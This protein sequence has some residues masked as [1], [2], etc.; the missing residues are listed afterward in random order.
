MCDGH[1]LAGVDADR[2][3]DVMNNRAER[4]REACQRIPYVVESPGR[5]RARAN[6]GIVL[7]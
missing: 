6:D 1:A 2:A 7:L 5:T 4:R 3:A